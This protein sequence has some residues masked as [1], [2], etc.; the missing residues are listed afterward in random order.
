MI[1]A[2]K[3]NLSRFLLA[4]FTISALLA[5]FSTIEAGGGPGTKEEVKPFHMEPSGPAKSQKKVIPLEGEAKTNLGIYIFQLD[6]LDWRVEGQCNG[7]DL[8]NDSSTN[9][10]RSSRVC[11]QLDLDKDV[12]KPTEYKD[13]NNEQPLHLQ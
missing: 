7:I 2:L 1:L 3:S 5:P 4:A 10:P 13:K 9:L 8:L 11:V 6:N 12:Y